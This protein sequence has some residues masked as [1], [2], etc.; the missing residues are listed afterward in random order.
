MLLADRDALR[1]ADAL[2]QTQEEELDCEAFLLGA[3][4]LAEGAEDRVLLQHAQLCACCSE[5]LAALRACVE[6]ESRG[7]GE[8]AEERANSSPGGTP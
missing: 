5:E 4:A 2:A 8:S 3:A 7:K 6:P 1:L